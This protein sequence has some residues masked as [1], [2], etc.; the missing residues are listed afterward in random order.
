MGAWAKYESA[1]DAKLSIEKL[2]SKIVRGCVLCAR[3][4]WGVTLGGKRITDKTTHTAILRGI[5]RRRGTPKKKID[6]QKTKES[7]K[8]K[9]EQRQ[10]PKEKE[11]GDY[12]RTIDAT[13][14]HK[15][16]LIGEIEYPFP[17]G[18]YL[19]KLIQKLSITN[20]DPLEKKCKDYHQQKQQDEDLLRLL[21][22]VSILGCGSV[23]RYVK[24]LSEVFAMVDAVERAIKLNFGIS[25]GDI[26]HPVIC[27]CLGDGKYPIGAAA[28]TLFLP[29]S[30]NRKN[31]KFI[32]IDPLLSKQ[33]T[34]KSAASPAKATIATS[35]M[36]INA[37]SMF[38]DRIEVFSGLSQDYYIEKRTNYPSKLSP[39][40]SIIVACHSHA[41]LEEFWERIPSPKLCV[42][43][44][45]CA[46]FSELPKET[47]IFEYDNYEVYS[48][49]H[50]IKIFAS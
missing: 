21:S 43:M 20:N 40:L 7:K 42:A 41:P 6:N 29:I 8:K 50:R 35:K 38:H 44:P 4:E 47:P 26:Q 48:P 27:Y 22:D 28:L 45:C 24:E 10:K 31:W 34:S 9:K 1:I 18:I 33:D 11:K 39:S 5:Q 36:K 3:L 16:I 32:A 25:T 23:H 12:I 19:S 13:Y 37:T 49:K 15:S 30:R 14:S 17:S 46:Q 2:Q